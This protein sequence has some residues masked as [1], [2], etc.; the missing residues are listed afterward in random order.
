[1]VEVL[2]CFQGR[3]GGLA[4]WC[5][6]LEIHVING[7][8]VHGRRTFTGRLR[9][10]SSVWD[11]GP[12]G[13]SERSVQTLTQTR[14]ENWH[15]RLEGG[16]WW[17]RDALL[18]LLRGGSRGGR[19]PG[20]CGSGWI[21]ERPRRRGIFSALQRAGCACGGEMGSVGWGLWLTYSRRGNCCFRV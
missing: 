13:H 7:A 4:L 2:T 15:I 6:L 3:L 16:A 1:M 5:C 19:E 14:R 11:E 20:P 12:H 17:H 10:R 18:D 21:R 8:G 9:P